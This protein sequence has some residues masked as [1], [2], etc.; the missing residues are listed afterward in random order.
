MPWES[1]TLG[2]ALGGVF[3]K[4]Q[5][6]V[7]DVQSTVN[8]VSGQLALIENALSA[9]SSLISSGKTFID[10]LKESGFY[11]L[12]LAPKLG[13]WSTR[14]NDAIDAPS[15]LGYSCGSATIVISADP[16]SA[17]SSY[18]KIV[19]AMTKPMFD[20]S[21]FVNP[22]SYAGFQSEQTQGLDDVEVPPSQDWSDIFTSDKW[23]SATLGDVF[24]G[25][26]EG[27]SKFSN[28]LCKSARSLEA[29]KE[30]ISKRI[31][32]LNK[33]LSTTNTLLNELNAT[34]SYSIVLEPGIGGI[35]SRLESASGA[36][37]SNSDMYSAGFIVCAAAASPTDL[38]NKYSTLSGLLRS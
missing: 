12:T 18:Q 14:A 25:T 22:F 13:S 34:G 19:G 31:Y 26:L 9:A 20:S 10:K 30:Q 17:L 7:N 1:M 5:T 11:M 38:L 28:A 8:K 4:A 2:T 21:N 24:G 3:S 16:A 33:G 37:P 23:Q 36:P 6:A 35:L 15:Q 32:A 29:Q 27:A